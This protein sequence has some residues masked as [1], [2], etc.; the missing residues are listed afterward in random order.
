M[1]VLQ[2][3]ICVFDYMSIFICEWKM[4]GFINCS[5]E[6]CLLYQLVFQFFEIY[7]CVFENNGGVGCVCYLFMDDVVSMDN[8]MLDLW[9]GQQLLWKGF[10]K[11]SEYVK[12]RVL[13]NFMVYINI[14]DI[15]LLIWSNLY[16]FDNYLYN[17]FIYVVNIWSENDLVDFRIY[18]VIYL[19]FIFCILVSILKFG[20]FYRVWVRVW[21]QYY[22]IIW[23]E[24]S[25]SI[26]WYNF[27]REF[28]EQCFV[29][30]VS[31]F[32]IVIL[33]FCLLCYFGIIKIKKG[34]WD[35]IFNLVCSYFVVIIIQDVQEL[36][37]E[38]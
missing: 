24:W 35:Q 2:E 6:F 19:K 17:D 32:C 5:V 18:N 14:F 9:V 16:F 8:Y 15:V 4:G 27:Y 34:W 28:F 33:V 13:G 23:S 12:F 11:F 31:V 22:N 1:K 3:F 20:I 30:G 21:V 37:W 38:K 26:K 10:F 29:W 36:Q 7:M 25:F